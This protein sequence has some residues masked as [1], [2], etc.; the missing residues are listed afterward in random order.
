MNRADARQAVYQLIQHWLDSPRVLDDNSRLRDLGLDIED[1][2]ALLW[3]LE[4]RFDLSLSPRAEE[5]WVE[6]MHSVDDLIRFV[7]MISWQN[8]G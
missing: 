7:L 6:Q 1:I 5:H 2:E 4:D 8:E 3:R